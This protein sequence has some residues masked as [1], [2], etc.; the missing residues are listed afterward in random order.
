M[1]APIIA[2]VPAATAQKP[3]PAQAEQMLQYWWLQA[4][5]KTRKEFMGWAIKQL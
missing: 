4:D 3:T 2:T 1:S 5:D